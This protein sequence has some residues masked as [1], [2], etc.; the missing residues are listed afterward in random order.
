MNEF[1]KLSQEIQIGDEISFRETIKVKEII[2]Q[3]GGVYV[4]GS[5]R[6]GFVYYVQVVDKD[7][8]ELMLMG[9]REENLQE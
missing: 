4:S 9:I 3:D 6:E 2:N 5:N 7:Q 1:V 8:P